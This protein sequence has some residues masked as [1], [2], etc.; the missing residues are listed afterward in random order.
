[1]VGIFICHL[2]S[3]SVLRRAE[4]GLTDSPSLSVA[5]A[6]DYVCIQSSLSYLDHIVEVEVPASGM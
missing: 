3:R 5:R 1:M 4:D 2:I 6:L